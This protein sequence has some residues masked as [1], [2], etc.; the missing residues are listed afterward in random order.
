MS[1]C[2]D[3][4]ALEEAFTIL[5]APVLTLNLASDQE[6][7]FVCVRLNEVLP[8]GESLQVSYGIL[9]LTHRN[10][11]EFPETLEPGE[12]YRVRVQLNDIAHT[13]ASGSRI[14]LAVSTAFW[15]IVWPSPRP[16]TLSLLTGE[17]TLC[18]P[19][20]EPQSQDAEAR[21]LAPPRHSRIHPASILADAEP[22]FAGIKLDMSTGIQSFINQTDSGTKHFDR[23]G[24]THSTKLDYQYHIHPDDPTSAWVDLTATDTYS[25]QGQLDARIEAHQKMTCDETH[26]IVEVSLDV[27]NDGARLYSRQWNKR[28]ARDGI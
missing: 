5:G 9:N 16:V 28:I 26:F 11:H 6:N 2:F 18:L 20:R 24:W 23:H 15:P 27:F 25:R 1:A 4:A 22:A 3:G 19:A 8:S 7:A 17:S 21:Q 14:R 13:F 12:Y 10:S